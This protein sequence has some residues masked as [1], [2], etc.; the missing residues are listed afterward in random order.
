[1][2]IHGIIVAKSRKNRGFCIVLYDL[3]RKKFIRII[4]KDKTRVD[5]ELYADECEYDNGESVSLKDEVIL[6]VYDSNVSDPIQ[7]EN[8]YLD[9]RYKVSFISKITVKDLIK[10]VEPLININ[11]YVFLNI[12]EKISEQKK[13]DYSFMI[14]LVNNL[15]FYTKNICTLSGESYETCKCNFTYKGK[16]YTNISMTTQS[17][18]NKEIQK[19]S[20]KEYKTALVC[21]SIG[22]SYNG[23]HYKFLCSILGKEK[24]K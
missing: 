3:D 10:F 7:P 23:Y 18:K 1:M 4:S 2:K 6:Y 11:D 15:K 9:T 16:N 8:Y 13:L 12:Y 5:S 22:H 17:D 21:F 24:D 20:G 19:Y 14:C